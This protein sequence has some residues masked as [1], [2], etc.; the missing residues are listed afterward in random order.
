MLVA[1]SALL[2]LGATASYLAGQ[3]VGPSPPE[4]RHLGDS[5]LTAPIPEGSSPYLP[6]GRTIAGDTGLPIPCR[7]VFRGVDFKIGQTVCMSTHVG[8]VMTRCE[9]LQN[10]T[11]WTPTSEP[12]T[13]SRAP[14]SR[15][16]DVAA[17]GE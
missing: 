17:L 4:H 11:S 12:C 9:L 15:R 1:I 14:T 8:T 13:V 2:M 3:Q 5:L 10:N 7:C 6:D 16:T